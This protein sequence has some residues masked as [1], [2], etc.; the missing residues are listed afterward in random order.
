[1]SESSESNVDNI[2]ECI[3]GY[4]DAWI[5]A[6]EFHVEQ[7]DGHVDLWFYILSIWLFEWMC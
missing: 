4:M 3:W 7:H 1:M 5:G 2:N 6:S